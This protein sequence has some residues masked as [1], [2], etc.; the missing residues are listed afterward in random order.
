M[1][2]DP[3]KH[4]R[5]SIRL[6]GYDYTQAGAYFTTVCTYQRQLLFGE[7]VDGEMQLSQFGH[8]VQAEWLRTAIVR[9]NV[10][11]DE[12]IIMP[13]HIHGII[14]LTDPPMATHR[15]THRV[16]PTAGCDAS[17]ER[18]IGPRS[19]SIGAIL[20]QFKS[21]VSKRINVIRKATDT[22]IW[23]RDYHDHIIRDE[24]ALNNIRQYIAENP[25]RWADD[26]ENPTRT[27]T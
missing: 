15:A 1:K 11:L 4:H 17:K 3:E 5:R 26:P 19:G 6:Q 8:I 20:G 23:Q 12:F 2:F 27:S 10:E 9:P 25:L 18:L 13:N 22:P 24:R 21:I 7:V 16:A 14:V